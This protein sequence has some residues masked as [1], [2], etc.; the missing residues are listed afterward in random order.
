MKRTRNWEKRQ[1]G[2][3]KYHESRF[4]EASLIW[5]ADDK[6]KKEEILL[7]FGCFSPLHVFILVWFDKSPT[8]FFKENSP[9]TH[10]FGSFTVFGTLE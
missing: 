7:F 10:L 6:L 3:K 2:R 4:L 5:Q 9:P 1:K 8:V